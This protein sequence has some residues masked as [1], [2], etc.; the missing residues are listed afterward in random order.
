M[1]M[2]L[3][4]LTAFGLGAIQTRLRWARQRQK[5]D[6]L[7]AE[8]RAYVRGPQS[9]IDADPTFH[10]SVVN[11]IGYAIDHA[12]PGAISP[13]ARA[14]LNAVSD[15]IRTAAAEREWARTMDL[16]PEDAAAQI[17]ESRNKLDQ[18]CV[19]L[20]DSIPVLRATLPYSLGI[21]LRRDKHV[22]DGIEGSATCFARVSKDLKKAEELAGDRAELLARW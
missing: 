17:R 2:V 4:A 3:I 1:L 11:S 10:P 14:L 12:A 18:A 22:I 19:V 5:S 21:R 9:P 8:M 16:R 13:R 6:A 7:L 20:A 15:T